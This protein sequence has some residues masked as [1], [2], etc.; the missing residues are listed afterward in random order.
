[1]RIATAMS[2]DAPRTLPRLPRGAASMVSGQD[3][4]LIGAGFFFVT[5]DQT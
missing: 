1:M 2:F 3:G 4:L 5:L